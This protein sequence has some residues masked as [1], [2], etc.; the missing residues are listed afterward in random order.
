[1]PEVVLRLLLI[2][3]PA[4]LPLGAR[5]GTEGGGG[6]VG[7]VFTSTAVRS[8]CSD[9]CSGVTTD[10]GTTSAFSS[11]AGGGNAVTATAN[12]DLGFVRAFVS[13]SVSDDPED[14]VGFASGTAQGD[15]GDTFVIDGGALNGAEG[16]VDFLIAIGGG[17]LS[18]SASSDLKI[19]PFPAADASHV[20]RVELRQE[21]CSGCE[22]FAEL[23][24]SASEGIDSASGFVTETLAFVFGEPIDLSVQGISA[25]SVSGDGVASADFANT[26]EWGGF[27]EVRDAKGSIVTDYT[28]VAGSGV[29]WSL[30]VGEVPEP[31]AVSM[32][33]AGGVLLLL[34]LS[35][36]RRRSA[37]RPA[38]ESV[39]GS[40][41]Q[42]P[43]GAPGASRIRTSRRGAPSAM[44][45]A[46]RRSFTARF[47]SQ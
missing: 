44:P 10:T 13:V 3:L 26:I 24:G 27:T 36:R 47:R 21:S 25:A 5:A 6:S 38:R 15:F 33:A 1:M 34:Q 4:T 32:G 23:F 12:A 18:A 42:P 46:W 39:A 9:G 11:A 22:V 29:D 19:M 40:P 7:F 31:S 14:P 8:D 45:S 16:A 43:G 28:V 2:A 17:G 30:P 35:L 20:T 41:G 37:P